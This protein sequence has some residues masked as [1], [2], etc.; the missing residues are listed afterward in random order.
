MNTPHF[1]GKLV[2]DCDQVGEAVTAITNL[3]GLTYNKRGPVITDTRFYRIN[4]GSVRIFSKDTDTF[5]I[6]VWPHFSIV[7]SRVP[8]YVD[9]LPSFWEVGDGA[10]SVDCPVKNLLL[11]ALNRNLEDDPE[12]RSILES[13]QIG[14][15]DIDH[16]FVG[17]LTL[18]EIRSAKLTL[19]SFLK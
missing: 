16:L 2:T 10:E 12:A 15:H 19:F 17:P 7:R 18:D 1:I 5:F 3:N 4:Y 13:L 8:K 14:R 9:I 11:W 6:L